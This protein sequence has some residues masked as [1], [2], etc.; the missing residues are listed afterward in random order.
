[1]R[2]LLEY[3]KRRFRLADSSSPTKSL[4]LLLAVGGIIA[5]A[6]WLFS[7]AGSA[8]LVYLT[9]T[10]LSSSQLSRATTLLEKLGHTYRITD[11]Y[12]LVEPAHKDDLLAGLDLL[13]D[14]SQ[15]QSSAYDPAANVSSI[16]A[17]ETERQRSWKL[18]R[19]KA[20]ASQIRAFKGLRAAQVFLADPSRSGFGPTR[21]QST[22]TVTVWTDNDQPVDFELAQAIRQTVA[23]TIADLQPKNVHVI[24]ASNGQY[25]PQIVA[26]STQASTGPESPALIAYLPALRRK[27]ETIEAQ[28]EQKIRSK[29]SYIQR[30]VVSV[31]IN[32][33]SLFNSAQ[34][35]GPD[36]AS[37]LSP[38][39][40]PDI[41]VS[42]AV[43]RSHLLGLYLQQNHT[44]AAATDAELQP[45]AAEQI[46]KIT[47]SARA[48][49]GRPA[50]SHVHVDWY[51]DIPPSAQTSAEAGTP[52]AGI[53]SPS[54][55]TRWLQLPFL[56]AALAIVAL[57]VLVVV[58]SRRVAGSNRRQRAIALARLNAEKHYLDFSPIAEPSARPSISAPAE[59]SL[60]RGPAGLEVSAFEELIH[61][62][63]A[64][65]RG[66]LRRTDP[67]IIALA[68][69]TAPEKLR[70]RIL[71]G[72]SYER[73]QAVHDHPDFLAPV[74]LSDIEAAQQEL[75]D[76]LEVPDHSTA[77]LA[78]AADEAPA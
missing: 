62:D 19:E 60:Y 48:I 44:A 5:A 47:T 43:P 46:A 53:D 64:T 35:A 71:A 30:L 33:L 34:S 40:E 52:S 11:S 49:I 27:A 75:V 56:L 7:S 42:I 28:W 15:A 39:S 25:L 26:S 54:P 1:M 13:S 66:L 73:R 78:A 45:I 57:A 31:H 18:N 74:R 65:L 37:A 17:S 61:L 55:F 67:Q 69:R 10:P 9:S 23:G 4:L 21:N 58:L 14:F 29:L 12:I 20:L 59:P 8:Q 32:P 68:L 24:D 36:V 38:T 16:F 2:K 50:S 6:V 41:S 76:L 77:E 3:C 72:L 70:H 22:A 51:Y 63:D